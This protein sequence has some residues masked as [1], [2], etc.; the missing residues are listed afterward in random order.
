MIYPRPHEADLFRRQLLAL[1]R[2]GRDFVVRAG[3]DFHQSALRTVADDE[4]RPVVAALEQ[5]RATVRAQTRLLL[6]LTMAIVTAFGKERLKF[7]GEINE[8]TGS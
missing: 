5:V 4:R 8:M 1:L 2:H 6:L 7:L 3:Q